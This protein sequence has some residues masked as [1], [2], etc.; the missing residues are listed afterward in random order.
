MD[1]LL[2]GLLITLTVALI[3]GWLV[4]NLLQPYIFLI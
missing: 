1:E 2:L 4:F 3:V